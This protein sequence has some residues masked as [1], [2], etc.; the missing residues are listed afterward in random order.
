MRRLPSHQNTLPRI[1]KIHCQ[2]V[3][4]TGVTSIQ[5][6]TQEGATISVSGIARQAGVD[7]TFLY[8]HRHRDLLALIHAAELQPSVSDPAAGPPVSLASLQADLA[9]THARN[10]GS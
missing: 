4:T 2:C 5:H 3:H 6:A 7:R 1:C 10:T 8:R 9:N